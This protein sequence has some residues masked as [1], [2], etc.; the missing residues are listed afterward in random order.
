[1]DQVAL[2]KPGLDRE[3]SHVVVAAGA[4]FY[5]SAD[6][7]EPIATRSFLDV[8]EIRGSIGANHV[9]WVMRL[10]HVGGKQNNRVQVTLLEGGD[11]AHQCGRGMEGLENFELTWW[12]DRSNLLPVTTELTTLR[13]EDGT[14][15]R[16]PSGVPILP[17][18]ADAPARV[19]AWGFELPLTGSEPAPALGSAFEPV[20]LPAFEP[21][22]SLPPGGLQLAGAPLNRGTW[23]SDGPAPV[24]VRD[25]GGQTFVKLRGGCVELEALAKPEGAG[26]LGLLGSLGT[27]GG[28]GGGYGG[29]SSPRF[30]AVSA[31]T[32]VRWPD[33]SIAG[34]VRA[35]ARLYPPTAPGTGHCGY[36][37]A[38][39]QS[40]DVALCFA[41]ADVR[42]LPLG[43]ASISEVHT[44][45]LPS[46][47]PTPAQF[48]G[49]IRS[50]ASSFRV[51]C[52]SHAVEANPLLDARMQIRVA[53]G[54]ASESTEVG[55][56]WVSGEASERL[57][58]CI[59]EQ[60]GSWRLAGMSGAQLQFELRV[61]ARGK[62]R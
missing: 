20:E 46:D 25:A 48:D 18:T 61:G 26:G 9:G 30:F 56:E 28:G 60:V 41:D 22:G 13:F 62:P 49:R 10:G 7:S 47:G 35:D 8:A 55:I 14:S 12:V 45:T 6:A 57:R 32:S 44:D 2:A 40:R 42:Q 11:P 24:S 3:G 58:E 50:F 16:L 23:F 4:H 52:V 1:L 59:G 29:G 37:S 31:G 19:S 5:A 54:S 17:A 15:V 21:A 39:D 33:G 36:F 53:F 43:F 27:I 38:G 51:P 34:Q